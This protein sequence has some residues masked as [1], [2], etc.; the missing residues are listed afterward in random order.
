MRIALGSSSVRRAYG[1]M[2]LVILLATVGLQVLGV[3]AALSFIPMLGIATVGVILLEI[4]TVIVVLLAAPLLA[5]L[6]V[7]LVLPLFSEQLFL[8]ALRH[9]NA[10]RADELAAGDGL[11][12]PVAI[13]ASLRRI[14]RVLVATMVA[15]LV[16]MIPIAGLVLGPL[17]QAYFTARALAWEL[18]DPYFDKRNMGFAEQREFVADHGSLMFGFGLPFVWVLAIPIAGPLLF[19]MAQAA[20]AALVNDAIERTTG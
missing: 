15:L 13:G 14:L 17:L 3:W 1:W 7:S 18:L 6:L 4:V 8:A 9:V 19:G 20:A 10:V 5:L 16:S 2:V 11:P 12:I